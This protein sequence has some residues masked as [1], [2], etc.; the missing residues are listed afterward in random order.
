W[1]GAPPLEAG[2]VQLTV[3]WAFPAVAATAVGA[4][5]A[6]A[7]VM[8]LEGAE[9]TP[10]PFTLPAVTVTVYAVPFVRPVT[11]DVVVAA[12]RWVAVTPRGDEVT[13]DEVIGLP[14]L[15]AGAVQLTVASALPAAAV[16]PVGAPGTVAEGV[17]AFDAAEAGPAP[18]LLAAVTE[19]V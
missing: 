3:T 19:K 12:L 5:G 18:T 2:A 13:A 1:I 4:P 11:A 16:T 9:A 10:E 7:G 8:L 14:P 6:V 15:E 17:T